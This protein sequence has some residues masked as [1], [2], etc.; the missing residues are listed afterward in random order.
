M[1]GGPSECTEDVD[2]A[3]DGI[4]C[5]GGL[6]CV[7]GA[8]QASAIPNCNDGV[9]CTRDACNTVTDMCENTPVNSSCPAGT[10]CMIGEG[11]LVAPSCEFD[12]DCIGDGIFCNGDEVCVMAMCVS[13][14]SGRACDDENSCTMDTCN[15]TAGDCRATEYPDIATNP[16]N[17]GTGANDCVVCP[18]PPPEGH[19]S[20]RCVGGACG[21]V[22]DAGWFDVNMDPTDWCEADCVPSMGADDPDDAF[23]D[24]NCDGIDGDEARAIFVAVTG[25]DTNPG[26]RTAPKRTFQ[27]GIA[28]ASAAGFDVYVSLGVYDIVDTLDLANGVSVYGGY[29][30]GMMWSRDNGNVVEINGAT[31]AIRARGI[32]TPTTVDRIDVRSRTNLTAG[33]A[34]IAVHAIDSPGLTWR[35]SNV[36]ASDGGPG[37]GGMTGGVGGSG[38]RG[39]DSVGG[40]EY[41]AGGFP[42]YCGI[43]GCTCGAARPGRVTGGASPC[44]TGGYGGRGG[45]GG[46]SGEAGDGGAPTRG[47]AGTAGSSGS[48]GGNGGNGSSGAAGPN[49]AGGTGSGAL[50]VDDWVPGNGGAGGTGIDG[51]AGGGGGGGGGD[52]SCCCQTYGDTGASGGGAGCGGGAGTPG[53]GGGG[54]IGFLVVRSSMTFFNVIISTGNGGDGG[55]GGSGG[56]G[57]AG[58]PGGLGSGDGS[59]GGTR[60]PDSQGRGGYGGNGGDGGRGGHGGGG[61]GGPSI[62]ILRNA[63]SSISTSVVTYML[64]TGG[65]GGSSSGNNGA[66]GTRMNEVVL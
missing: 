14:M 34:S 2:C 17:C 46:S 23:L 8:C 57:G 43:G 52:T 66:R 31:T 49:G 61:A 25:R 40:I 44:R 26:T 15:E 39:N 5:N 19:A 4:F 64:G 38:S 59:W 42:G 21:F 7:V 33:G 27:A 9:G 65:N 51:L 18:V 45:A 55:S 58:A 56:T 24:S 16:M 37:G 60:D 54:S 20:P 28:A 62:G 63:A 35:I 12:S 3:D 36:T 41:A 53:N 10:V 30:A 32:S 48:N 1:D 29:N 13:P 22:C 6:I 50:L 11:C 47:S